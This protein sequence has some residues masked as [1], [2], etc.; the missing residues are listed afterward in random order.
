MSSIKHKTVSKRERTIQYSSRSLSLN[1]T[2]LG[3]LITIETHLEIEA[4][5]RK[6]SANKLFWK[7][8]K[9]SHG[10]APL[11]EL[12]LNKVGGSSRGCFCGHAVIDATRTLTH[13]FPRAIACSV[14]KGWSLAQSLYTFW[15]LGGPICPIFLLILKISFQ[16]RNDAS[17]MMLL[18]SHL[19]LF[20]KLLIF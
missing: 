3:W 18:S 13:W 16:L 11:S 12:G 2:I 5:A 4:V 19:S 6:C 17:K 9:I 15:Q 8:R 10:K 7:D 1:L 14:Y 20:L